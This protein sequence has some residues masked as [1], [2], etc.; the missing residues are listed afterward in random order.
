[1]GMDSFHTEGGLRVPA[2]TAQQMREVDGVAIEEMGP[3]LHQMMEN[4]GRSLASVCMTMLGEPGAGRSVA[5][6]AGG[7]QRGWRY[8]CCPASGQ[9][10]G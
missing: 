2:V 5:V 7:G 8:L 10:W 4:A 9:P 6:V 3:N 1:M